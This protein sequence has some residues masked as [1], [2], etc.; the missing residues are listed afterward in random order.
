M[1]TP[2]LPCRIEAGPG[3]LQAKCPAHGRP[4]AGAQRS[5][6]RQRGASNGSNTTPF[7]PNMGIL[8]AKAVREVGDGMNGVEHG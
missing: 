5:E 8:M 4:A 6:H 7:I 2:T 1:S 3:Q